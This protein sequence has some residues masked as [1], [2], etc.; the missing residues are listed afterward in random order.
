[1]KCTNCGNKIEISMLLLFL[2]KGIV[3]F[4]LENIKCGDIN[5]NNVKV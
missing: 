2:L 1:M 4:V 3:V 5:E